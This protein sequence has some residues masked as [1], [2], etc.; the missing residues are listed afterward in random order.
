VESG[1][2]VEILTESFTCFDANNYKVLLIIDPEDYFNENEIR[3][4]RYDIE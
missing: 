3:K 4:L 2:F 1:F